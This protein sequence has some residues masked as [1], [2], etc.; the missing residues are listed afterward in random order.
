MLLLLLKFDDETGTFLE[1]LVILLLLLVVFIYYVFCFLVLAVGYTAAAYEEDEDDDIPTTAPVVIPI[2]FGVFLCEI[3][4]YST[5]GSL[6][7]A[8]L[9]LFVCSS[10]F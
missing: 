1:F 2:L 7:D 3:L 6:G 10:S 8:I 4:R 9:L 5:N